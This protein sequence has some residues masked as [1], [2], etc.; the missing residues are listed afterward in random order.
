MLRRNEGR[1]ADKRLEKNLGFPRL[2][3]CSS[4]LMRASSAVALAAAV[5]LVVL[6]IAGITSQGTET[7]LLTQEQERK[8]MADLDAA[9]AVERKE[10]APHIVKAAVKAAPQGKKSQSH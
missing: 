3:L 7:V 10:D 4:F 6:T 9:Q 1:C 8:L 5:M 2:S